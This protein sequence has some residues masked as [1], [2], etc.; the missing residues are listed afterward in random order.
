[1][2]MRLRLKVTPPMTN[3]GTKVQKSGQYPWVGAARA[4]MTMMDSHRLPADT[5]T[6]GRR[7]GVD[8][9]NTYPQIAVGRVETILDGASALYG[10]EAVAG[11]INIIPNKNF[12]GLRINY[13]NQM[14][15][16]GGAPNQG[17]S[18]IAGAQENAQKRCS[19]WNCE[20]YRKW[21]TRSDQSI[22]S[23]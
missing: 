3:S 22:S 21:H 2:P 14:A 4:T 12:E 17:L 1:M 18:M 6:W 7:T 9:T 10:A 16:R 13:N 8:V 5:N 19:R 23:V 11:V 20:I 15:L